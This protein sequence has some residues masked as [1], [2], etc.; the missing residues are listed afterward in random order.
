MKSVVSFSELK[1]RY[2][3]TLSRQRLHILQQTKKFPRPFVRTGEPGL[4]L[5]DEVEIW[6]GKWQEQLGWVK[7]AGEQK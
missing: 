3:I 4:Y 2:G 1:S 7:Q 5:V 6:L